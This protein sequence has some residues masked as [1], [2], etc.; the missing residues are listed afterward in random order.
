MTTDN[1]EFWHIQGQGYH[2]RFKDQEHPTA[3]ISMG[4]YTYF[5]DMNSGRVKFVDPKEE[6]RYQVPHI[7]GKLFV[8]EPLHPLLTNFFSLHQQIYWNYH[9]FRDAPIPKLVQE[10]R[11]LRYLDV[12][13][14]HYY[15][16]AIK[17]GVTFPAMH[18]TKQKLWFLSEGGMCKCGVTR[19]KCQNQRYPHPFECD[20][21]YG[22]SEDIA[23]MLED[24]DKIPKEY[25]IEI[26]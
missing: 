6:V 23:Q 13:R 3:F 12:I 15:G 5:E 22:V 11:L 2:L 20:F 9:H 4:G 14:S 16:Y 18:W 25:P 10:S 19:L 7:P 8:T 24:D 26:P 17:Y 21:S 1:W